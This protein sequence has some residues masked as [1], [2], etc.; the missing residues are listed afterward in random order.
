MSQPVKTKRQANF[1]DLSVLE[2][3]RGSSNKKTQIFNIH[4]NF[5][6]YHNVVVGAII[7]RWYLVLWKKYNE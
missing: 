3:L 6:R 2:P 4:T 7:F 5:S 1:K